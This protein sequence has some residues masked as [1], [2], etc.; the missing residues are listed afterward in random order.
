MKKRFLSLM[1]ML[2]LML[3]LCIIPTGAEGTALT[4]DFYNVVTSGMTLEFSNALTSITGDVTTEDG[5][6]LGATFNITVDEAAS[7]TNVAHVTLTEKMDITK[8][9]FLN[10]TATDDANTLTAT[11]LITFDV[12][13]N[14]DFSSYSSLEAM[15][16][17]YIGRIDGSA[18]SVTDES[19]GFEFDSENGRVKLT[20]SDKFLRAKAVNTQH[21]TIE[22]D[23]E[24]VDGTTFP[25]Y[26][27]HV[28]M[29]DGE[30]ENYARIL[31][32][33]SG[34]FQFF[35]QGNFSLSDAELTAKKSYTISRKQYNKNGNNGS[36]NYYSIYSDSELKR[37]ATMDNA[38]VTLYN[39]HFAISAWSTP[40][41]F[42][43]LKVYTAAMEDYS[44]LELTGE[45]YLTSGITLSL[46]KAVSGA[47]ATITNGADNISAMVTANGNNLIIK[48]E[49]NFELDKNYKISVN[50]LTDGVSTITYD[51]VFKFE[52]L[53]AD[54]FDYATNEEFA[55]AYKIRNYGNGYT[56]SLTSFK[57][58]G[59]YASRGTYIADLVDGQMVIH[60]NLG[61]YGAAY[62]DY[63]II[64]AVTNE[65]A[66]TDYVLE[67]DVTNANSGQLDVTARQGEYNVSGE[68]LRYLSFSD[69]F[70]YNGNWNDALA[71][72]DAK[73][74]VAVSMETSGTTETVSWYYNGVH[75]LTASGDM[76]RDSYGLF[77]FRKNG[78]NDVDVYIDNLKAYKPVVLNASEIPVV[79][80]EDYTITSK[81]IKV[82]F[83]SPVVESEL[84]S[85]VTVTSLGEAVATTKT[86]ENSGKTLVIKPESGAFEMDKEI[87]LTI[88]GLH[89]ENYTTLQLFQK[90]FM[91]EKFWAEDFE[92]CETINDLNGDYNVAMQ[93]AVPETVSD[94]ASHFEIDVEDDGNKRLKL[95]GYAD[96]GAFTHMASYPQRANWKDLIME[97]DIATDSTWN[98]DV[99]YKMSYVSGAFDW[100]DSTSKGIRF[101]SDWT[102]NTLPFTPTDTITAIPN[103]YPGLN[104][105]KE[106][107]LLILPEDG[108]LTVYKNE[109]LY[110]SQPYV[111]EGVSEGE[112]GFRLNAGNGVPQYVDN[113]K[114][115]KVV[116][117]NE[118]IAT[119]ILSAAKNDKK[120]NGSI[121]VNSYTGENVPSST[122]IVAAYSE[123]NKLIDIE[124]IPLSE[125]NDAIIRN[126][127]LDFDSEEPV[128]INAFL[129]NSLESMT[130][131]SNSVKKSVK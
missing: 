39:T 15:T 123:N 29:V 59:D 118:D 12:I 85:A 52:K 108:I 65:N 104:T 107:S 71:M 32:Y 56:P 64:P 47:A 35:D 98:L 78:A 116:D 122:L 21:N 60:G 7:N 22:F 40:I 31:S 109:K 73:T 81:Y 58:S 42:D 110:L 11:K 4:L 106:S 2:A 129:W 49:T 94:N 88:D 26:M 121:S 24:S 83:T 10:F 112:F 72:T 44:A 86:L 95:A 127:E 90:R 68:K 93:A 43:N 96:N 55:A 6:S 131:I 125:E 105:D 124:V 18:P 103:Q 34:Y 14:D 97:A 36:L 91:L 3:T 54:S 115:Y 76:F 82:D 53:F 101:F 117:F 8:N 62:A 114:M 67:Y 48:P 70:L 63:F 74:N 17:S 102:L 84:Q 126:Y 119:F 111:E 30:F 27:M 13:V 20:K 92:N 130:S 128:V 87:T 1:L 46:N 79:E 45:K 25:S 89:D 120:V 33:Y 51:K 5:T 19:M 77:G 100:D 75:K 16:D 38:D 113:I 80:M 69:T 99:F 28:R 9:Y 23:V 50:G 57:L 37:E 61:V 66:F 41:Y